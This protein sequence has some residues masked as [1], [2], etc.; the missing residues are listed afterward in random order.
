ME[1]KKKKSL[2]FI[3]N[4]HSHTTDEHQYTFFQTA[5]Y[6]WG[7]FKWKAD[8]IKAT[9]VLHVNGNH[10]WAFL[11]NN[12]SSCSYVNHSNLEGKGLNM[13]VKTCTYIYVP[14]SDAILFHFFK[15]IWLHNP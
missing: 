4:I 1:E 8:Q 3:L 10:T 2:L 15:Q 11:N 6:S 7:A 14:I 13:C 9:T 5:F 12:L